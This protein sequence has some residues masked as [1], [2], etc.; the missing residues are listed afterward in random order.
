MKKGFSL[1]ELLI[2]LA[3]ISMI[4]GTMNVQVKNKRLQAEAKNIVEVFKIYESALSMYY[5][6]H[7]AHLLP[8]FTGFLEEIPELQPY[9]PVGFKTLASIRS[10]RCTWFE[11]ISFDQEPYEDL[12]C[13]YAAF[14][15][16]KED[17]ELAKEVRKQLEETS[18][19]GNVNLYEEADS[20]S[21]QLV[22]KW[23][24]I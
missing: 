5:L 12:T 1:T 7:G 3:I 17:W 8:T 19:P 21:L 11:M 13:I 16:T 2:V 24:D 18:V 15:K 14:N 23:G 10:K 4:V 9:C 22:V 20:L 6:R